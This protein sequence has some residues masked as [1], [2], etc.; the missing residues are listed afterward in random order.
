MAMGMLGTKCGRLLLAT[1]AAAA[2]GAVLSPAAQ[3]FR[4]VKSLVTAPQGVA[5]VTGVCPFSF[6]STSSL[7]ATEIDFKNGSGQV[8][9][10]A[11]HAT[12]T[13]VFTANGVTLMGRPYH[14]TVQVQFDSN[15]NPT[16][17]V[18]SG[19]AENMPLPGGGVFLSAG[20]TDL[21]ARGDQVILAPDHGTSGNI[22][23]LCAAL[24]G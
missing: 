13:D 6:T 7:T 15:G 16:S 14:F 19:I 8:I 20:T 21:L 22:P 12:E 18:G 1:S 3:A 17:I 11:F 9:R 4:P 10:T 2:V 24:A 5:V 23:A